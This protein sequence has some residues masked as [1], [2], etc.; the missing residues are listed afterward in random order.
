MV[1][2][3]RFDDTDHILNE[4]HSFLVVGTCFNCQECL[5][6]DVAVFQEL[7]QTFKM[8]D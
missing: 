8:T 6:T 4:N 1:V 3:S 2:K 7:D 5:L